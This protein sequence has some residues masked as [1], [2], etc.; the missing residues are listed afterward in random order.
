MGWISLL[1]G[2]E[3][4]KLWEMVKD[5]KPVLQSMGHKVPGARLER[6]KG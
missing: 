3:F 2:C 6:L 4:E 1:N 5:V